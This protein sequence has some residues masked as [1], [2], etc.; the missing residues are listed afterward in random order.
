MRNALLYGLS[1]LFF[2]L[3][4]QDAGSQLAVPCQDKDYADP[5]YNCGT[6]FSPVC[7][8]DNKTYKN[9]CAAQWQGGIRGS[10]WI[11]G[12]CEEFYFN[13]NSVPATGLVQIDFMFKDR[14]SAMLY[15]INM[16]GE[17]LYQYQISTSNNLPIR[18]ELDMI[19]YPAGFYF[20]SIS[21]NSFRQV[22]KF[23]LIKP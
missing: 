17:V 9:Q 2:L 3:L 7:A 4:F 11:S 8:C 19:R 23:P 6:D 14:G 15:L 5:W 10:Q 12:P 1:S 22:Q 13:M 16:R 18:Y 21:T 20:V